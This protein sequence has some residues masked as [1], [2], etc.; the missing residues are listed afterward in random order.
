MRNVLHWHMCLNTQ[1]PVG[2]AVW[3]GYGIFKRCSLAGG[4]KSLEV[5]LSHLLSPFSSFPAPLP[6]YVWIKMW[7]VRVPPSHA[8]LHPPLW[9]LLLWNQ[10]AKLTPRSLKLILYFITAIEKNL[11]HWVCASKCLHSTSQTIKTKGME[12]R[13]SQN[14]TMVQ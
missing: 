2:G 4:S 5:G 3:G 12:C 6:F 13:N 8:M 14:S 10:K 9:A 1:S 7:P 11:M